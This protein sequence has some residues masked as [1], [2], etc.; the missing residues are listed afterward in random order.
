MTVTMGGSSTRVDHVMSDVPPPAVF[1]LS[2]NG[3]DPSQKGMHRVEI[4]H[5]KSFPP[6]KPEF[7]AATVRMAKTVAA[8]TRGEEAYFVVR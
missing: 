4:I 7:P 3:D 2:M 5:R 8:I 6:A 1:I